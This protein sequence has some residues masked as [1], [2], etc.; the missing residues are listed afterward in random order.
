[1]LYREGIAVREDFPYFSHK[2]PLARVYLDSAATTQKPQVVIDR[3]MQFYL[4]EYG[5]VHRA[6]YHE[7]A[8]ATELYHQARQ[9]VAQFLHTASEEE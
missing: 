7:A 8:L 4:E 9:T 6:I 3:M 5:T 2:G 1:M